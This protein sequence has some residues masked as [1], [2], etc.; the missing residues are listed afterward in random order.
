MLRCSMCSRRVR[1][2]TQKSRLFYNHGTMAAVACSHDYELYKPSMLI[3]S[4][5]KYGSFSPLSCVFVYS[6]HMFS[7]SLIF[8]LDSH[9]AP[10]PPSL[11]IYEALVTGKTLIVKFLLTF[12]S[13]FIVGV[14]D[15]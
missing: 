8:L 11:S 10:S 12:K 2:T 13:L 14:V 6:S 9:H 7:I 3:H 15:G 1:N 5:D 4:G